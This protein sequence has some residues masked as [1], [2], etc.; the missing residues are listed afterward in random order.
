MK[1]IRYIVVFIFPTL[2][3]SCGDDSCNYDTDS[4]LTFNFTVSDATLTANKFADSTSIYSTEWLD[5]IN[6]WDLDDGAS[7]EFS[8]S[9]NDT[10]TKVIIASKV[11]TEL[12]TITFIHQNEFVYLSPECGFVVDFKIDTAISTYHLIDSI[13]LVDDKITSEGNG[14]IEVYYL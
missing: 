8:L 3:F 2:L 11:T 9:P 12:D 10:I 5:T 14:L 13:S 7:F 1:Y 6:K 4:L